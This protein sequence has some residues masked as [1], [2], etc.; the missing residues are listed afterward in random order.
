MSVDS[1]KTGLGGTTGNKGGVGIRLRLYNS[2]LCFVCSHFAA[3]QSQYAERNS[4]YLDIAKKLFA[5]IGKTLATHDYVFWCG[6]FNYRVDMPIEQ[7]KQL[8]DE[9]NWE[10]LL[11]QDQLKVQQAEGKCFKKFREGTINFPPTYKYDINSDDYDTSEKSRIPAWTDR[12]LFRKVAPT[13]KAEVANHSL[14]YG[15]ILF[16]GRAELKTSDHRPVIG[17]FKID[18]LRVQTHE[19]KRTFA[20]TLKSMGPIDATVIIK[21]ASKMNGGGG[22]FD[23]PGEGNIIEPPY[24]SEILALINRDI[25]DII[26]ARFVDDHIRVT[27]REGTLALKMASMRKLN[28]LDKVFSVQLKT[29]R[30]VESIEQDVA[31]AAS[32]TVPLLDDSIAYD[33]DSMDHYEIKELHTGLEALPAVVAPLLDDTLILDAVQVPLNAAPKPA[34]PAPPPPQSAGTANRNQVN[35][36]PVPP[37]PKRP[38]VPQAHSTPFVAN[39]ASSSLVDAFNDTF[40]LADQ[41]T[42]SFK[43]SF[44]APPPAMVPPPLPPPVPPVVSSNGYKNAASSSSPSSSSTGSADHSE[45]EDYDDDDDDDEDVQGGDT[46]PPSSLPPPLPPCGAPPPP[47]G[48]P[49]SLPPSIPSRRPLPPAPSIPPRTGL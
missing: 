30:W 36:S 17:E 20:D 44:N 33:I 10:A 26:L 14:N 49:P 38:V 27:F 29:P 41:S 21:E 15:E 16:Y 7:V 25:G 46:G 9:Q 34:R 42:L 13:R 19:L 40:S 24:V 47:P 4:D 1:V 39:S 11:A 48:P 12:V 22:S 18:L 28:I 2:S 8:V 37:P 3:G 31:S 45:G 43:D 35:K 32:N 5:S 23:S 6:D